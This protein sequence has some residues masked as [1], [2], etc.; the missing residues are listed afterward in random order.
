MRSGLISMILV[1]SWH[2]AAQNTAAPIVLKAARMYDGKSAELT[3]PGMVV[4]AGNKIIS[5]ATRA[6]IPTG[7]QIIDLGDATLL[8]GF[9]DA[10]THLS[11]EYNADWNQEELNQLKKSV[12]ELTL[13]AL[14]NLRVT[15]PAGLQGD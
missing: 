10:H 11:G 2:L 4:I 5:V 8:P 14:S 9:M 12:P 15:L 1:C 13:D 3:T 6:K 7:A